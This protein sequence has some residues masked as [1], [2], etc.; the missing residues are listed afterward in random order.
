MKPVFKHIISPACVHLNGVR[1]GVQQ[2]IQRAE[3]ALKTGEYRYAIRYDIKGYYASISHEILQEQLK[4]HFNDPRL[5]KY[6]NLIITTGVEFNGDIIFPEKGIPIRS[7]LSPFFGALYL[8][9]ERKLIFLATFYKN[10][11]QSFIILLSSNKF[12]I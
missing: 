6:L 11:F 9:S 5:L 8:V 10:F 7:S 1:A 12:L 3:S 2:A 4:A